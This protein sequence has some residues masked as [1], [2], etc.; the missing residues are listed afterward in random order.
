MDT[1]I[2]QIERM[3]QEMAREYGVANFEDIDRGSLTSRANGNIIRTLIEMAEK[4]EDDKLK[5]ME[6]SS[7]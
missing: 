2:N 3:K 1:K 4:V 6:M 5:T 7:K